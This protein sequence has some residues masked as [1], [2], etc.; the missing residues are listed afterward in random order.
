MADPENDSKLVGAYHRMLGWIK[1]FAE[2]AEVEFGPKINYAIDAAKEKISELGELT[3]EEAEHVA[4]YIRRDLHDAAVYLETEGK[5]L[6]D[7][8]KFDIELVED[9]LSELMSQTI[10]TASI[11]LQQLSERAKQE[12]LW[13]KGEVTGPGSFICEHCEQPLSFYHIQDIPAC[14]NCGNGI[15]RRIST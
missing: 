6:G 3:R 1:D 15:F 2:E 9:R 13:Y 12:N 10:N 5:D 8:L 7:W 14:P 4:D 11:E